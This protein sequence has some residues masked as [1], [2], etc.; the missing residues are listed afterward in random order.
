M[1]RYKLQIPRS[2]EREIER[3]PR[4]V[5]AKIT[6]RIV[7]LADNPRPFGSKKLV[8]LP[9]YR[10]RQGDYRIVYGIDDRLRVVDVVHVGHRRE[11]YR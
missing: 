3:L 1:A 4:G 11:I 8:G 5:R 7:S 9:H 2:A 6:E 10:L